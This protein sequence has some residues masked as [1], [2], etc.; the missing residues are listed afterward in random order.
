MKEKGRRVHRAIELSSTDD[1]NQSR[2]TSHIFM[3]LFETVIRVNSTCATCI[4]CKQWK[5]KKNALK[6][7]FDTYERYANGLYSENIQSHG[8]H[9][10]AK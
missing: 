6:S 7:V 5:T 1:R 9:E 3:C 10:F 8:I 4:I 2:V